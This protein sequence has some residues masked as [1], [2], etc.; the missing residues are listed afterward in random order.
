MVRAPDSKSGCWGFESL[1][2]CHFLFV[3][4]GT[5]T[6]FDHE[7]GKGDPLF[8]FEVTGIRVDALSTP[9]TKDI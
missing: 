5:W 3:G 7:R 6:D 2:A 1:L 8:P 9:N 4:I